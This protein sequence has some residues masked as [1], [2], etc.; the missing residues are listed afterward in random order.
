MNDSDLKNFAE[1]LKRPSGRLGVNVAKAMNKDNFLINQNTIENLDLENN[2]YI[3]EI[4]MGNGF[5]VKDIFKKNSSVNY[6]GCDFSEAMVKKAINLN[7]I[8]VKNRQAFFVLSNA[9]SLPFPNL[10][11]DKVFSV[12]TIYFW[13]KPSMI[14]SEIHRVLKINGEL[15]IAI[16]PKSIMEQYPYTQFGF[17]LYER[18]SVNSGHV[19][20]PFR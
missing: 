18:Y 12:H 10:T 19:D 3:L 4:G 9:E 20:P 8:F 13:N 2:N 15:I 5:F 6:V 11:F 1:Q 16:R 17:S 14:L 7:E